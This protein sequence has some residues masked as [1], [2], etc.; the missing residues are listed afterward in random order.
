M[1][2]RNLFHAVVSLVLAGA[3]SAA[4]VQV[5][6]AGAGKA[7]L[8]MAGFTARGPYSELVRTVLE[9]DLKRSGWF[10]LSGSGGAVVIQG[11]ATDQDG[12]IAVTC[13]A[14]ARANAQVFMRRAYGEPSSSARRLAHAIADD[15]VRAVKGVPGIASTRIAMVGMRNGSKEIYICDYDGEGLTQLTHDRSICLT[16]S[17]SPDGSWLAYTA[18]LRSYPDVYGIDLASGQRRR[19]A[20]FPGLNAGPDISRDGR[21]IALTLSKDGN[22]E[23]YTLDSRS[24]RPTRLTNTRTAV[25]ASPT[26]SPD[27]RQ[28]AFVSDKSGRPQVYVMDRSGGE[29]IRIT[30]R[31]SENAAPDWGPDGRIV[32]SS[33]REGNYQLC[34][35]DPSARTE[36]QVTSGPHDYE[37]PSWA[38]N[39]RHVVCS[40]TSGYHSEVYVL[41]TAG[42]A[43][44][45]LHAVPGEWYSPAWSPSRATE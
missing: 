12:R 37:D 14:A 22:P 31:G 21:T 18:F 3:A 25:E 34:V 43:P 30:F 1:A 36:T 19:I 7:S 40:R 8:D 32:F 28:I 15:V 38:P 13:Q 33:R 44:I 45:R 29:A 27:G 20:G 39:G 9:N 23:L 26:W 10:E 2:R 5:V 35:Y 11:S 41:D 42:D 17:W 24:G 4:D 16:P 6:K